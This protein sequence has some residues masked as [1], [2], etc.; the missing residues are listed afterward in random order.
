VQ[1]AERELR[2]L[3]QGLSALPPL[4]T[5]ETQGESL[6]F[7]SEFSDTAEDPKDMI[8]DLGKTRE[9]DSVILVP[10]YIPGVYGNSASYGFPRRFSVDVSEDSSF[11]QAVMFSDHSQTDF[12]EPGPFPVA[13]SAK[14]LSGRFVRLRVHKLNGRPGHHF[15]ALGEMFM[16]GPGH[17]RGSGLPRDAV[18]LGTDSFGSGT[19]WLRINAFDGQSNLGAAVD[20][21][22]SPTLGWRTESFGN[23]DATAWAS[24]DLGRPFVID[25]IRI[26]SANPQNGPR[27]AGYAFPQSFVLE[28]ALEEY[29]LRS[30][31][32]KNPGRLDHPSPG[33][34]PFCFRGKKWEARYLRLNVTQ[35]GRVKSRFETA[36]SEIEVFS[37]GKNVA[38]GA[39]VTASSSDETPEWTR[40]ALTDGYNSVARL[41][42][43]QDW[44]VALSKRREL[45]AQ[46]HSTMSVLEK[47][48]ASFGLW[49][50]RGLL[51]LAT[52][53][54]LSVFAIWLRSRRDRVSEIKALR[55]RIARDLHDEIGS[56]LGTIT[57]LS[58]MAL[59]PQATELQRRADVNEIGAV[60]S[61]SADAIRDL[62]WL[63]E[64]ESVGQ[65]DLVSELRLTAQTL[66]RGIPCVFEVN[67]SQL[68]STFPFDL[69][70]NLFL[71]FKEMLHNAAKHSAAQSV[72]VQLDATPHRILLTVADDGRGFDSDLPTSGIGVPSLKARA[73]GAGGSVQFVSQPG[74]GTTVRFELPISP[75]S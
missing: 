56:N 18:F 35:L 20:R 34:N 24:I 3:Q 72:Q 38:L 65:A 26:H 50:D 23:Q 17:R 36:L 13:L 12:L 27:G 33:T 68:P 32:I 6:G 63:L 42:D 62:V 49:I 61:Q 14:P 46:L 54:A 31:E 70:R 7:H 58:Q 59:D 75:N 52:S 9:I 11:A 47:Q 40:A 21:D 22:P 71:A 67:S 37:G 53:L 39:P 1:N 57:M 2:L 5:A 60:A 74:K 44:L 19:T 45:E 15:F 43:T 41:T 16:F 8:V 28:G 48:R 73:S 66:L 64:K 69:R 25:E 4:P 10:A 30:F 55:Q 51:A 29:F